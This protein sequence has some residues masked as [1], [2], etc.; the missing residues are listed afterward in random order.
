MTGLVNRGKAL[1][2]N[3]TVRIFRIVRHQGAGRHADSATGKSAAGQPFGV[4]EGFDIA[5]AACLKE[6]GYGG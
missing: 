5:I 1:A 6:L 2:C 3:A 4:S